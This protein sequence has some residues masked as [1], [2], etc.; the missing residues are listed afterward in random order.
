MLSPISNHISYRTS[1]SCANASGW[2]CFHL[3]DEDESHQLQ[4]VC[5]SFYLIEVSMMLQECEHINW[6]RTFIK[7][8]KLAVKQHRSKQYLKWKSFWTSI[9]HKHQKRNALT[10]FI[11]SQREIWPINKLEIC[12]EIVI[13]S[14]SVWKF[15]ESN[16]LSSFS[17]FVFPSL[18]CFCF[19]PLF[20][21]FFSSCSLRSI[22]FQ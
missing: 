8:W 6:E 16:G 14:F 1:P 21:S 18:F 19:F 22:H 2:M 10:I 12:L 9:Y 17:F 4:N 13:F 3:V 20:F 15:W 11:L 5:A 7:L